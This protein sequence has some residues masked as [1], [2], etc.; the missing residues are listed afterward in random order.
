MSRTSV[1]A[2]LLLGAFACQPKITVAP[3]KPDD[4]PQV[5][6]RFAALKNA[7]DPQ[8]AELLG[9]PPSVPTEPITRAEADRLNAEFFLRVPL[10]VRSV[11]PT[12][13]AGRFVLRTQGEAQGP[14]L[15]V[16]AG[17]TVDQ[18]QKTSFN[19]DIVVEVR[20]GI[21]YGIETRLRS[22]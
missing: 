11:V 7:H 18:V 13:Q 20:D 4:R 21:I 22:D 5:V 8:A 15:A 14:R 1:G 16:R 9:P 6:E 12:Q 10:E 2:V 17:N 3:T 19:P